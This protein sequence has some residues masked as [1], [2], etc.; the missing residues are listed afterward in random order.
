MTR[1]VM[2]MCN[3]CAVGGL[4]LGLSNQACAEIIPVREL[5]IA[6]EATVTASTWDIE[7]NGEALG[8]SKW[9]TGLSLTHELR[10]RL[11]P[12]GNT[13]GAPAR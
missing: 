7:W 13:F 11:F 5:E 9:R 12:G 8:P 1:F 2:R 3:T 6:G 10:D 4:L